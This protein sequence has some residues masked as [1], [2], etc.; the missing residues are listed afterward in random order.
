[1]ANRSK[2]LRVRLTEAEYQAAVE[3]AKT[4]GGSLSD[5]ARASLG[6]VRIRQR[7]DSARLQCLLAE[8]NGRLIHIGRECSKLPAIDAAEILGELVILES[9]IDQLT[10]H[11]N[12]RC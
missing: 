11:G 12:K 5:F 1:M 9:K 6:K 10:S 8:I 7:V 2:T 3:K 4:F